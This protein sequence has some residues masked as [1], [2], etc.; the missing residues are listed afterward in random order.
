MAKKKRRLNKAWRKAVSLGVRR[1]FREKKKEARQLKKSFLEELFTRTDDFV[2]QIAGTKGPTQA[3]PPQ[4][5]ESIKSK[6]ILVKE[7]NEGTGPN[8]LTVE[9]TYKTLEAD[10]KEA[11]S[12]KKPITYRAKAAISFNLAKALQGDLDPNI[13]KAIEQAKTLNDALM[14]RELKEVG[15]VELPLVL[16]WD[17]RV[18]YYAEPTKNEPRPPMELID[19]PTFEADPENVFRRLRVYIFRELQ[20]ISTRVYLVRLISVSA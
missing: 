20:W 12:P 7:W 4:P 10:T 2:Q 5:T 13:R 15:E 9:Q 19:V 18:E 8:F 16:T 6:R 3:G 1:Y 14:G 17:I 11:L